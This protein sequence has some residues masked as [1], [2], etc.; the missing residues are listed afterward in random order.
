[1][2]SYG[3]VCRSITLH[4]FDGFEML[5]RV[6]VPSAGRVTILFKAWSDAQIFDYFSPGR[7]HFGIDLDFTPVTGCQDVFD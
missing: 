6:H 4:V 3:L 7:S 1:M 2:A 5:F